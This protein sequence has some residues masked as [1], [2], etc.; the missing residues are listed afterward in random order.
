MSTRIS[1]DTLE[2]SNWKVDG[3]L[4]GIN[5]GC[6]VSKC[7]VVGISTNSIEDLPKKVI[8][9]NCEATGKI[10]AVLTAPGFPSPNIQIIMSNCKGDCA[11]SGDDSSGCIL[12]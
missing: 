5:I 2:M 4:I 1:G 3:D 12:S 8:F 11:I 6:T 7:S 10:Y 9:T